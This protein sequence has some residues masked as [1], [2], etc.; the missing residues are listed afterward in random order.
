MSLWGGN[1]M[2]YWWIGV[3]DGNLTV[4]EAT[5]L[6]AYSEAFEA[7]FG[8]AFGTYRTREQAEASKTENKAALFSMAQEVLNNRKEKGAIQPIKLTQESP[9]VAAEFLE[10]M[11][12][13]VPVDTYANFSKSVMDLKVALVRCLEALKLIQD[14]LEDRNGKSS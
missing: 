9:E 10:K 5:E 6:E 4:F 3:Q 11:S 12:K 13:S 7:K 2:A 14:E 1:K 8:I